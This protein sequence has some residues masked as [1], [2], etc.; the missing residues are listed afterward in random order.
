MEH[1]DPEA[2]D[3]SSSKQRLAQADAA[4]RA[5][6]ARD[7]LLHRLDRLD[8]VVA[9]ER[10]V[11]SREWLGERGGEHHL[12]RSLEFVEATPSDERTS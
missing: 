9:H 2:I 8:S 12:G 3:E 11:G 7:T 1:H 4:D 5:D 10:E 6:E